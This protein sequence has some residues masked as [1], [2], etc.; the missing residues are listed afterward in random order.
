MIYQDDNSNAV[1]NVV[2]IRAD[3]NLGANGNNFR[4]RII[5]CNS[6]GKIFLDKTEALNIE[7]V[8]DYYL[9]INL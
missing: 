2:P 9:L 1:F 3:N 8:F 7:K 5:V 4:I 6:C